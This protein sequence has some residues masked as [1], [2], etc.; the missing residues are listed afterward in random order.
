[1]TRFGLPLIPRILAPRP[2]WEQDD[3]ENPYLKR[4]AQ[5]Q[6]LPAEPDLTPEEESTLFSKTMGA[7]RYFGETLDKP[8]AAVRG[9]LSGLTGGDWGGGLA[10]LIPFSDY[11]GRTDPSKRVDGRDLLEQW[12]MVPKNIPGLHLPT[13]AANAAD[14]A[15]DVGG[16]ALALALDPLIWVRGPMGALTQAGIDASKAAKT[17]GRVA[18][19][20]D[21]GKAL[22]ETL[23]KLE[24]T[25]DVTK[26][27]AATITGRTLGHSTAELAQQIRR[28]ERG[29]VGLAMPFTGTPIGTPLGAGSEWA[30]KAMETIG[31]GK[32]SPIRIA[33]GLASPIMESKANRWDGTVQKAAD[34]AHGEQTM[35]RDAL[36]DF[37]PA[38]MA[39][40]KYL[41]E[42]VKAI[43][44][45]F[46]VQGDTFNFNDFQ[47]AIAE[48]PSGI[49][50]RQQL[51]DRLKESMGLAPATD[52]GQAVAN[53][54]GVADDW[55]EYLTG[56]KQAK[57]AVFQRA[58]S[59]GLPVK[60]LDDLFAEH[61]S[62]QS[63]VLEKL[64]R[65][66]RQQ[67]AGSLE[68]YK[69]LMK[70]EDNLRNIPGG[71]ETLNKWTRD[72]L[73]TGTRGAD[74]QV[75][76][77]D[78]LKELQ[79]RG[80]PVP[81]N[82][83]LAD[84][85]EL[86]VR[87]RYTEA[88]NEAM[89]KGNYKLPI[90]PNTKLPMSQPAF[91]AQ[92]LDEWSF[93]GT[94]PVNTVGTRRGRLVSMTHQRYNRSRE[95]ARYL[96]NLPPEVRETGLFDQTVA[97]DW[98]GYMDAMLSREATLRSMHSYLAE[99]GLI[100]WT[101]KA[102]VPL[103]KAWK[104]AGF[105]P[106][107]LTTFATTRN[108]QVAQM[109]R[110]GKLTP[111]DL[112]TML[113]NA[114]VHPSAVG[115]LSAFKQTTKPYVEKE[116]S[117]FLEKIT[118]TY[119]GWWF[120]PFP[121]SHMR[122]LVSGFWQ[123]WSDGKIGFADLLAGMN[124]ARVHVKKGFGQTVHPE[125]LQFIEEITNQGVMHGGRLIETVGA[126]AADRLADEIPVGAMGGAAQPLRDLGQR[127]SAAKGFRAKA[128][129]LGAALN[130]V[131]VRGGFTETPTNVLHQVGEKVY[132]D[133]EFILRAGYYDALRK[134]GYSPAQAKH[135]VI[136]S[137]FDY[138]DISKFEK[139]VMRKV[140]PF[141][142]FPRKNIPYQLMKL[143]EK[144]GG[145]TA[146]LFRA[147]NQSYGGD[148]YVP[149]FLRE[150]VA[151]RIGGPDEDA[152]FVR[153]MGMPIEDL[154]SVMFSGGMLSPVKTLERLVA[155]T[156]P[157]I[158]AP[159]EMIAGKQLFT[160][161]SIKDL[162]GYTNI[163]W[164]DRAIHY[165]P[166]SRALREGGNLATGVQQAGQGDLFEAAMRGLSAVSGIKTGSYDVEKWKMIDY[167]N[168]IDDML[169]EDP[170]IREQRY[171]FMLDKYKGTPSAAKLEEKLRRSRALS[172]AIRKLQK[173]RDEAKT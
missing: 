104:E 125:G 81:V 121:S 43:A 132:S 167:Q 68:K 95:M 153:A 65:V 33:R 15:G 117:K 53:I 14:L 79:Q 25:L 173:K 88:L 102:G 20:A 76:T 78:L 122:N 6:Q 157:A 24:A 112:E 159:V 40:E 147:Y 90:D 21:F 160:G 27:P 164:L 1:M 135:L 133:V 172:Q 63:A 61:V 137:Q 123:A 30:A 150:G 142:T 139:D 62:R 105:T 110:L 140:V 70:R 83:K 18:K 66:A 10:N 52:L 100:D 166:F 129:E 131:S 171:Q 161:R 80:I 64:S 162:E 114:T 28:G 128:K 11:A 108:P 165:T 152:L 115:V 49:P 151:A 47:R 145:P 98:V 111:Q 74:K 119:R 55:F 44:D 19:S 23:P 85:Q 107:G 8:G 120:T 4:R 101:G 35:L 103:T 86:Y 46:K 32:L 69:I 17:A 72:P 16:F 37:E 94:R 163:P 138:A 92:Q 42:Q 168:L 41:A 38:A 126:E 127:L 124:R 158:T 136:R 118:A 169:R 22:A 51:I 29:I 26:T 130:P 148:Q 75:L 93:T 155:R 89:Q 67:G 3:E 39:R 149:E 99:P 144:P 59:L 60:D 13:N 91:I 134:A 143:A 156:S 31:Y 116:L 96:R 48:A 106:E 57:D 34:L 146:Q 2:P 170:R 109:M 141:W 73:M 50:Q 82:A 45:H 7:V 113:A 71:A 54:N 5:Q 84:L 56:L 154:N 36:A 9:T 87:S 12:G 97:H 58:K 77:A